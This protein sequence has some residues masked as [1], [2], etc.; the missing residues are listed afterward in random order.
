MSRHGNRAGP[1]LTAAATPIRMGTA[2]RM[3][4]RLPALARADNGCAR[5]CPQRRLVAGGG[6][7]MMSLQEIARASVSAF[8]KLE[9]RCLGLYR[10][11][12][13]GPASS[14]FGFA[15]RCVR[16]E[17]R[18]NGLLRGGRLP[19]LPSP[20]IAAPRARGVPA[21]LRADVLRAIRAGGRPVG[22]PVC[23]RELQILAPLGAC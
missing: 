14:F 22:P 9:G 16:P 18:S 11:P 1:A 10:T 13:H 15:A 20:Q 5:S 4:D 23:V 21:F 7:V 6:G 12:A 3:V 19:S 2:S 8:A 17:R